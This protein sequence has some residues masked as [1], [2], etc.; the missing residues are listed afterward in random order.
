MSMRQYEATGSQERNEAVERNAHAATIELLE[1]RLAT[2]E[3]LRTGLVGVI[4]KLRA[5]LEDIEFIFDG[6]EDA[7]DGRPND[8][9]RALA[10]TRTALRS[11]SST[12]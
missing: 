1:R 7:D 2:S 10:V 6:K 5:A 9:M 8:A 3:E 4:H 12:E 11:L